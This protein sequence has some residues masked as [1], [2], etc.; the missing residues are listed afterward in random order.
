MMN[1]PIGEE[2]T[3]ETVAEGLGAAEM[4]AAGGPAASPYLGPEE[5]PE[6]GNDEGDKGDGG[7]DKPPAKPSAR[8]LTIV[9]VLA[10][11]MAASGGFLLNRASAAASNAADIA[12]ELSLEGSAAET[13]AEQQAETDYGQYLSLQALKAEAAQEM[14]ESTYA[15]Q[16]TQTWDALYQS[17]SAQVKQTESLVPADL[18]PDLPDGDP[19]LQFPENFFAERTQTGTY[20][21]AKS[22]AYDDVSNKWS[23]L[24]D[25]YTAIL[26]MIAVSLFLFG[27]AY[28]L[29]GRNR[30]LF[31]ALG[32]L[33][34]VTGVA[35]GGVLTAA[36]QPGTPSNAAANDYAEGITALDEGS[37]STGYQAAINDFTAAIKLRPDYAQ[38]YSER[39]AAESYSGSETLG[40]GFIS[41]LSPRWEGPATADEMEAYA[42]GL[43]DASQ[44]LAEGWSYYSRWVT[45][46]TVGPAP[47]QG[48]KFFQQAAQLDP[49]NPSDWLDTGISELATGQY[50]AAHNA[51]ATAITHMLFTCTDPVNLATCTQPQPAVG[52]QEAWLGGG[53][54]S[55]E[56]L[57]QSPA[58]ARSP[59][60]RAEAAQMEGMLTDSLASGH[61]MQGP[62]GDDLTF[63]GLGGYV[64][65]GSLYLSVPVPRTVTGS[66][67]KSLPLTV[68]WY[69][70]PVGQANWTAI[71]STECWGDGHE[72]C[73]YYDSLNNTL[74]FNAYL[75]GEDSTCF[76]TRQYRAEVWAGGALAGTVTARPSGTVTSGAID[77][78]N[79]NLSPALSTGMDIGMCV[80]ST[81]HQQTLPRLILPVYGTKETVTGA[82]ASSELWYSSPDHKEGVYMFRLYPPRTTPT[83]AQISTSAF[84]QSGVT[85]ALSVLRG[86]G[87]PSDIAPTTEPSLGDWGGYVTDVSYSMY[88]SASTGTTAMVGSA[89][90]GP[91]EALTPAQQDEWAARD[92]QTD[93]AVVVTIVYAPSGTFWDGAPALGRLIFSSWTTLNLD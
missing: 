28:V 93:N 34:V 90:V 51:F 87:L 57:A 60:L 38:A 26:T 35:W 13:S 36:R 45:G 53:M 4:L 18:H 11:L 65:P 81:W 82:L 15:Q 2:A 70:R 67:V 78:V 41:V 16:G 85:Y 73:G 43:H 68:L 46:G 88:G 79:T 55:L 80:P 71:A 31:F 21:Q 69:Q 48:P 14:L 19:D 27:S 42:L 54:E 37:P 50:Q 66:V 22:N 6:E 24:V 86:I 92:V 10:T 62:Y 47:S 1:D 58:G 9:V 77:Y 84:I 74:Y 76:A 7:E 49:S 23:R 56:D 39:A 33:L 64:D 32:A 52:L 44:L 75:L 8:F 63:S 83:G 12:Q 3:V 91:D 40:L 61:L 5:R 89:L 20:L 17:T 72:D 59:Q 30:M 29:Y 25:S